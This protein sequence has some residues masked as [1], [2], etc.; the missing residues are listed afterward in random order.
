MDFRDNTSKRAQHI[1]LVI[2]FMHLY[3]MFRGAHPVSSLCLSPQTCGDVLVV[4]G[5]P[6]VLPQLGPSTP[7]YGK[8]PGIPPTTKTTQQMGMGHTSE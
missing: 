7:Y 2:L 8:T 6:E 4:G 1:H 3:V 5:I